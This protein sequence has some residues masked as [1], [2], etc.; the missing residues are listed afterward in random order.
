MA[1]KTVKK[2]IE[3][4]VEISATRE[5]IWSVLTGLEDFKDWGASSRLQPTSRTSS[6]TGTAAHCFRRGKSLMAEEGSG[7]WGRWPRA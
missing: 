1:T 6:S 3:K 2:T 4:S 7:E 5:Q